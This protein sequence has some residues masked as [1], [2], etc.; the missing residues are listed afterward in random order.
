[1]SRKRN[2]RRMAAR[3]LEKPNAAVAFDCPWVG[4]TPDQGF[5]L[6]NRMAPQLVGLR[7]VKCGALVYEYL[8]ASPIV[9]PD[10]GRI[11]ADA[12]ESSEP[13]Q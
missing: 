11:V 6:T 9:A 12:P 3:I 2:V 13:Q 4:H 8:P 5:R 1:M 10:G 7:C